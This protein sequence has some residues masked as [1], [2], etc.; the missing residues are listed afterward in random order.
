MRSLN[1]EI[2]NG[3]VKIDGYVNAVGRD[4]RP[5]PSPE[6]RF[7][8]QVSPGV[9]KKALEGAE[10]VEFR[11]NHKRVLGTTKDEGVKLFEDSIGLRA[12]YETSDPEII[13]KAEKNELR[14]WSF[15][16]YLNENGDKW[17]DT[18]SGMRRRYL[19]D[20]DLSEVSIIDS[21]MLPAYIG[22]SIETRN[23]KEVANEKR[24]GELEAHISIYS[25]EKRTEHEKNIDYTSY[26]E[27]I[28]KLKRRG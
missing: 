15:G 4:S 3:K 16:F 6:G 20:I 26:I 24:G 1:I 27:T 10:A 14:G 5:I 18:P 8:E 28:N 11:L 13:D 21:E 17:E 23:D 2:R 25:E 22:T 9:F 19:E 7:I 12:I